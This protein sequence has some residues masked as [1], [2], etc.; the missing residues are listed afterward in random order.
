MRII[1]FSGGGGVSKEEDWQCRFFFLQLLVEL[2]VEF[3]ALRFLGGAGGFR[4]VLR[5]ELGGK[6]PDV[7]EDGGPLLRREAQDVAGGYDLVSAFDLQLFGGGGGGETKTVEVPVYQQ[8]APSASAVSTESETDSER[9]KTRER[10]NKAR[11]R[12]STNTGAGLSNSSA[13]NVS[14]AA[15]QIKKLLGE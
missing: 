14:D 13:L 1:L 3:F 11:G 15:T 12:R 4:R 5:F 6:L 10:L 8:T 9:Q 2:A 7:P